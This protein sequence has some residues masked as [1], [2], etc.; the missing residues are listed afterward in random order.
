MKDYPSPELFYAAVR[1]VLWHTNF[2]EYTPKRSLE[3]LELITYNQKREQFTITF[4]D[5]DRWWIDKWRAELA[6]RNIPRTASVL[7][8]GKGSC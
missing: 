1:E 4:S 3:M 7:L 6:E 2:I 5:G 8:S